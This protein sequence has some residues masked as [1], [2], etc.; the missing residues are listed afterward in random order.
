M[1]TPHILLV[2]DNLDLAGEVRFHLEQEGF[3]CAL[4][5]SVAE[6]EQQQARQSFDIVVLDLGLPDGDGLDLAHLLADR[7]HLRIIM[8]T[9][10]TGRENRLIGLTSGADAYLTKPVDLDELST[11]IRALARRLPEPQAAY[12]LDHPG[13][14]LFIGPDLVLPLTTL[15]CALL[16]TLIAAPEHTASRDALEVALWQSQ[17]TLSTAKRLDILVHRLRQKL[18]AHL[19]ADCEP[20]TT[21]RGQ[22][23]TLTLAIGMASAPT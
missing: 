13:R 4:A 11:L 5:H 22:G 15:E 16:A 1:K 17:P 2:E 23:Y 10:R 20:I 8:L 19:P 3:V 7:P 18:A 14:R 21:R 6:F 9:A 12:R